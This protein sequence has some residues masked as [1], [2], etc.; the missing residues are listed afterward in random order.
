MSTHHQRLRFLEWM[1]DLGLDPETADAILMNMSPFDWHELA[2]KK[3]LEQ[4]ATKAD[5]ERL[6]NQMATRTDLASLGTE[7]RSEMNG[8]FA[9]LRQEMEGL[10]RDVRLTFLAVLGFMVSVVIAAAGTAITLAA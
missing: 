10:R 4:F 6:R 2:T 7:L 1:I 8:G 3:D 5:L 9:Q